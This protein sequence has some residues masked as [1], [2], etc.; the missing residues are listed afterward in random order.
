MAQPHFKRTHDVQSYAK[1]YQE[2]ERRQMEREEKKR[3]RKREE[4]RKQQQ[5]STLKPSALATSLERDIRGSIV[6]ENQTSSY[7][8][9]GPLDF[10]LSIDE[11]NLDL[12][13]ALA[14]AESYDGHA[15]GDLA[16]V[17][18]RFASISEINGSAAET[19]KYTTHDGIKLSE[20]W[21]PCASVLL[22]PPTEITE[23]QVAIASSQNKQPLALDS[24]RSSTG[25]LRLAGC[26]P[27]DVN[28]CITQ[29][30]ARS[31]N[32]DTC[33]SIDD[34]GSVNDDDG[35]SDDDDTDRESF[36]PDGAV[37]GPQFTNRHRPRTFSTSKSAAPD[38]AKSPL[39]APSSVSNFS[40]DDVAVSLEIAEEIQPDIFALPTPSSDHPFVS[41][42][43]GD[44]ITSQRKRD[45]EACE[46][47]HESDDLC[48]PKR[49]RSRNPNETTATNALSVR[50]LRA[51]PS[52]VLAE[53]PGRRCVP[54]QCE[55]HIRRSS[56]SKPWSHASG[57]VSCQDAQPQLDGLPSLDVD[58]ASN[59]GKRTRTRRGRPQSI[60]QVT[61]PRSSHSNHSSG[62]PNPQK[63][64]RDCLPPAATTV[65]SSSATC[66]TCGFSAEHLL[67]ISDTVE[68]L[69]RSGAEL[70]GNARES[71]ILR[72]FLGFVRDHAT[73]RLP[74]KAIITGNSD[75]FNGTNQEQIREAT[76]GLPN[77]ETVKDDDSSD[78]NSEDS[79]SEDESVGFSR[80]DSPDIPKQRSKRPKRLRWTPLDELRLR[81]WVQEEKEWSW[82]A[83]QLQRSEQGAFQHWSIMRK[84]EEELGK[85]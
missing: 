39:Y 21:S 11:P 40:V 8:S 43:G 27:N 17:T 20:H 31:E 32:G 81:A 28:E 49:K 35:S 38:P 64:G 29:D 6:A 2:N 67:Q 58:N 44:V 70:S 54:A 61:S 4:Q 48:L 34:D 72:L 16:H 3:Q 13:E 24:V 57:A 77:S 25:Q 51:R 30:K 79:D 78:G 59:R 37:R 46:E 76:V 73:K 83:G 42:Q 5:T 85:M 45:H 10:P 66:H 50:T 33:E 23:P 69:T 75:P 47:G 18:R 19:D 53:K 62:K 52:R 74:H 82:I 55:R 71:D 22:Q 15:T 63:N 60:P 80:S 84:R 14:T 1:F 26:V 41:Q 68:A 65:N 36:L 7:T 12:I 9:D 56:R